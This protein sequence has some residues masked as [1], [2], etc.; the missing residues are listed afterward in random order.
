MK[1]L[2]IILPIVILG[3]GVG[4]VLT[5]IVKIPG[6]NTKK[7]AAK[8]NQ[9]YTEGKD[10][11]KV[12]NKTEPPKKEAEPPKDEPKKEATP[13]KVDAQVVMETKPEVGEKKLAK[14]WNE[15]EA[16]V[17]KDIVKDWKD[18]ELASI[19][20]R[21]DSAKVAELLGTLEPKRA[22]QVSRELQK[23]AS[24]VQKPTGA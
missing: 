19:L 3:V 9:L 16:P 23:Q 24:V 17:L 1:K 21:M 2:F 22:S 4:L 12:A 13:P 18:A 20:V 5:G 6:I 10:A 15:L 11:P 14:L 8:A 7:A